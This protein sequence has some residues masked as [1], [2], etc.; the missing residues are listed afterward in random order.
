MI[1]VKNLNKIYPDNFYALSNISLDIK[2]GEVFALLGPNGAG[3]TTLISSVCGLTKQTSGEIKV[4]N[5]D[6]IKDYKKTR[7]LIGLVPQEF[8]LENYESVLNT[9]N[10]SRG[11]FGKKP[12]ENHVKKVLQ[13]LKLWDKKDSPIITLSGGMK[14]RVLI[15]KALSHNPKILFLDEPTSGVD[16]QLR[17]EMWEMI[18]KLKRSGVTVILTTHYIKEAETIAD[19]IGILNKGEL[20]LVEKK[21]NLINKFGEK[22]I[23]IEFGKKIYKIPKQIKAFDSFITDDNLCLV[24]KKLKNQ[25]DI[26]ITNIIKVISELEIPIID[27]KTEESSLEDIF[28]D[29]I[30]EKMKSEFKFN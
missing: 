4:S 20:I 10:F 13:S 17:K 5:F 28:L 24:I 19:R 3:K 14:R 30:D 15:A 12:D 29:I 27:I 21:E 16:I 8:P 26:N 11:L 2:Q 22:T 18:L 25:K 1:S 6:T 9:V 7:S 23:I